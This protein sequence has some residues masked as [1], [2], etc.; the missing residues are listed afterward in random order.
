MLGRTIYL[1]LSKEYNNVF[2]TTR[3]L[4]SEFIYLNAQDPIAKLKEIFIKIRPDFIVNCI[5][6]LRDGNQNNFRSINTNFPK[7]LSQ[8]SKDLDFKIINISSDAVFGNLQNQVYENSSPNPT[9]KYGKSKLAGEQ[10]LN[11]LNIRTSIIGL[12]PSEHKGILEF[13]I[14]NKQSDFVGFTNQKWSGATTIQLARFI[15]DLIYNK[16]F[17]KL[18]KKTH[19]VHF[20]PIKSSKYNLVEHFMNLLKLK[21]PKKEYGK[22]INTVLKSKYISGAKLKHFGTNLKNALRE[23]IN[24]DQEYVKTY[25]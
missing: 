21:K 25:K 17:D 11:T 19:I 23:M 7:I 2:G 8:I 24:F 5:G 15:E 12:D 4:K 9:D 20:A 1:Y 13:I 14:K 16:E 3:K 6:I 18:I 10:S 22:E